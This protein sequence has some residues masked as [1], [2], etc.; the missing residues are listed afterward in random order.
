MGNWPERRNR[1]EQR[2]ATREAIL[3]AAVSVLVSDGVARTTTLLVQERAQVSRGALLHHFPT[4]RE[5]LAAAI[6]ELVKRNEA[7]VWREHARFKHEELPLAVAIRTL[8]ASAVE[9][10]NAAELELW[11]ASRTDPVLRDA[12]RTAE[13]SAMTERR[14]VTDELF[15]C[16]TDNP[17]KDLIVSLTIELARGLVLSDILRKD[18]RM[19]DKL[20]D[21]W[22]AAAAALA[23]SAA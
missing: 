23:E 2:A 18:S 9:P 16:L 21:G 4:H 12:L 3:E 10:S 15:R 7:S 5:L 13:R 8:V 14:R 20:V 22:I 1:S 11:A 19:R 17:A 6:L